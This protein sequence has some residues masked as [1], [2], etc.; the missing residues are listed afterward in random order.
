MCAKF[1]HGYVAHQQQDRD[2]NM[3]FT[4]P[5]R[6]CHNTRSGIDE[7]QSIA[8]RRIKSP[9]E[10]PRESPRESPRGSPRGS[11][12]G[13]ARGGLAESMASAADSDDEESDGSGIDGMLKHA[14]DVIKGKKTATGAVSKKPVAHVLKKIIK[15]PSAARVIEC[16]GRPAMPPLKSSLPHVYKGPTIY[17]LR[18]IRSAGVWFRG[19]RC[20]TTT[21]LSNGVMIQRWRGRYSLD[22]ARRLPSPKTARKSR[23][24]DA[25]VES[26]LSIVDGRRSDCHAR[27]SDI[28]DWQLSETSQ[29]AQH[30]RAYVMA[31]WAR[32]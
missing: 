14:E 26:R 3:M 23:R 18:R 16:D 21:K 5:N 25:I 19:H 8:A 22:I 20:T 32:I 24:S 27:R 28:D 30:W 12:R 11:A 13:S 10:G 1:L 6:R 9:R 17:T 31:T 7:R 2:I 15:K 29:G 4:D